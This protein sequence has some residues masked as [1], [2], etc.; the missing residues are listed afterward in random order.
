MHRREHGVLQGVP[1]DSE[2]IGSEHQYI[3]HHEDDGCCD[4]TVQLGRSVADAEVEMRG[5][6]DQHQS[7]HSTGEVEDHGEQLDHRSQNVQHS[8]CDQAQDL[9]NNVFD[10]ISSRHDTSSFQRW[11]LCPEDLNDPPFLLMPY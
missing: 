4:D 5:N 6:S 1:H 3:L 2:V 10:N 9:G 11:T 8:E 7:E